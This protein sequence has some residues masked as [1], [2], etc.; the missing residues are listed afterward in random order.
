MDKKNTYGRLI[1]I[2]GLIIMFIGILYP[3]GYMEESYFNIALILGST[4]L[5]VGILI[6]PTKK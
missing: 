4:L 2:V 3:L 5:F 6:R 1:S